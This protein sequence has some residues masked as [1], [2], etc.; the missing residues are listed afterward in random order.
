MTSW[1]AA[2]LPVCS[3]ALWPS[4]D[5]VPKV[6]QGT[7]RPR[8]AGPDQ[9]PPTPLLISFAVAEAS[10]SGDRHEELPKVY[11]CQASDW[12][13]GHSSVGSTFKKVKPG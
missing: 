13:S 11:P 12:K 7:L 8:V 4:D 1:S 6:L 3:L 2:Y 9:L 5:R 10:R